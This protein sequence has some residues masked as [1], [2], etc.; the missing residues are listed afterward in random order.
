VISKWLLLIYKIIAVTS[1][2]Q[3]E[4]GFVGFNIAQALGAMK[5]AMLV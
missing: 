3:A 5:S 1:N 2:C 4:F